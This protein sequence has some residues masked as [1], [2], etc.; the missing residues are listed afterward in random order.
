MVSYETDRLA[1]ASGYQH[2]P[3]PTASSTDPGQGG[4]LPSDTATG[5]TRPGVAR[6]LGACQT[7]I[8]SLATDLQR[9]PP[10][11]GTCPGS[12]KQSI[13]TESSTVSRAPARGQLP[14][15]LAGTLRQR[16]GADPLP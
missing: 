3:R 8:C 15:R 4:A 10:A 6:R 13:P 1:D 12:A 9:F 2:H 16:Q 14:G 5:V 7:A 11:R